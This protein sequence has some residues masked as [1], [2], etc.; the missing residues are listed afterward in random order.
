MRDSTYEQNVGQ[1]AAEHASLNN[2]DF[3][4]LERNDGDLLG[5]AMVAVHRVRA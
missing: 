3:A 1:N 2:S 5:L 4:L